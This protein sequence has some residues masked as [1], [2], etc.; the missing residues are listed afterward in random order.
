MSCY[1]AVV[2]GGSMSMN[3]EIPCPHCTAKAGQICTVTCKINGERVRDLIDALTQL[4]LS[5]D[6]ITIKPR[7]YRPRG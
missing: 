7:K 1:L 4:D 2:I 6:E 5:L 3:L